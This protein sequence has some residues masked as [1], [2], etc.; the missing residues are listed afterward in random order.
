MYYD[1]AA[2]CCIVR[3]LAKLLPAGYMRT[4]II[5]LVLCAC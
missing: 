3:L 5:Y 4:Y 1:D 2:V